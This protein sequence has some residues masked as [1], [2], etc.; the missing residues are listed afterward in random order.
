MET[1]N[2]VS[3]SGL[4]VR[5]GPTVRTKE[6][7]DERRTA[8]VEVLF[9]HFEGVLF[10]RPVTEDTASISSIL[11]SQSDGVIVDSATRILVSKARREKM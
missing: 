2:G 9:C 5:D 8:S 4:A 3:S 1:S 10:L 11:L 6:C 7:V